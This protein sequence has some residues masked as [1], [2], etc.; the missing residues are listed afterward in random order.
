MK[1]Y[2][3]NIELY[4]YDEDDEKAKKQAQRVAKELNQKGDNNAK[5]VEI[6]HTP[7]GSLESRKIEL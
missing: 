5:V 7:F 3:I 6:H 2:T 1:R 4:I